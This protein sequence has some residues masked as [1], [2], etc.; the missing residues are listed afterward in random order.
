[1]THPLLQLSSDCFY[2]VPYVHNAVLLQV[3]RRLFSESLS[4]K[5]DLAT[6]DQLDAE[7]RAR[8]EDCVAA[9]ERKAEAADLSE[10]R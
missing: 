1:M 7:L 8:V 4:R 3:S 6:L 5:C 10:V 9:A 2:Q